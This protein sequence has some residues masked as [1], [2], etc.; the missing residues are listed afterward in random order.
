MECVDVGF[1]GHD[2]LENT[3]AQLGLSATC[4]SDHQRGV[5][6]EQEGLDEFA[7]SKG[8]DCLYGQ[9]AHHGTG[10]VF[11]GNETVGPF[12]EFTGSAIGRYFHVVVEDGTLGRELDLSFPG[13]F[14]PITELFSE[15]LTVFFR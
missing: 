15:I 6:H 9:I 12:G 10:V 4:V 8:L 2:F 14:P 13:G 5:F 1:S 7:G 3:F 11:R